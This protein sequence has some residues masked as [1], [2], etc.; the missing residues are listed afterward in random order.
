MLKYIPEDIDII[1][2]VKDLTFANNYR[3]KSLKWGILNSIEFVEFPDLSD[4]W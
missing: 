2:L 1:L 4:I 3:Q